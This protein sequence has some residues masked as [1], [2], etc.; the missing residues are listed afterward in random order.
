MSVVSG[1]WGAESSEDAAEKAASASKK[2]ADI[3]YKM[4]QE[5]QETMAPWIEA[6][7][8]ALGGQEGWYIDG[9]YFGQE[10]PT[11]EDRYE[12]ISPTFRGKPARR[13]Y[14]DLL[15]EESHQTPE[16][17]VFYRKK[18]DMP[19]IPGAEYRPASG[20]VGMVEAGPGEFTESPGYQWTLDQG[21][22]GVQR[23]AS[24]GGKLRGGEHMKAGAE[25]ATGLASTEYD[26]FLA[27]Y[28]Q[29]LAPW[30][31]L[32]GLGQ[33]TGM[34]MAGLGAQSAAMQGGFLNQAGQAQAAGQ[35]G[36]AQSYTNAL[37]TLGQAGMDLYQLNTLRNL[38]GTGTGQ[39]LAAGGGNTLASMV[40]GGETGLNLSWLGI[41]L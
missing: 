2:A 21:L 16:E 36:Q 18:W 39:T 11:I 37:G 19:E 23:A 34:G 1:I 31:S 24:A 38:F 27:R 6:G 14:A 13:M 5:T 7:E 26:N 32:A 25:Y 12:S 9:E 22:Q 28:Y 8:W 20:L 30:Q 3:Q 10:E 17:L 29:S 35:L 4:F 33:T 15:G 40:L 41:G